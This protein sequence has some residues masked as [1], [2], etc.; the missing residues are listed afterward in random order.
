[1]Y[2]K[3]VWSNIWLWHVL[4]DHWLI[5]LSLS[6]TFLTNFFYKPLANPVHHSRLII[7]VKIWQLWWPRNLQFL[8]L[9][10]IKKRK[11]KSEVLLN[12][13]M[14]NQ[15]KHPTL[16]SQAGLH[17][18]RDWKMWYIFSVAVAYFYIGFHIVYLTNFH[19]LFA[20]SISRLW[21]LIFTS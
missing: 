7:K 17:C 8:W 21:K 11:K 2:L 20:V 10:F 16:H 14:L 4:C 9:I 5:F 3:R 6:W 18:K 19:C 1:M 12:W 15:K 13:V